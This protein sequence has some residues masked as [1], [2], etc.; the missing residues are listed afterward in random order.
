MADTADQGTE[1]ETVTETNEAAPAEKTFTQAE[2]DAIVEQRLV[3]ER[4]K[5]SD[6][7]TLKERAA[8]LDEI[9]R[10]RLS[11]IEKAQKERDEAMAELTQTQQ[12]LLETSIREAAREAG[13]NPVGA[14]DALKG[15]SADLLDP[16]DMAG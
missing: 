16:T 10:E 11:D 8:R 9:E 12:R 4:K 7:E 14:L 15:S 5:F 1:T 3:R 2:I 6:Y 13:V